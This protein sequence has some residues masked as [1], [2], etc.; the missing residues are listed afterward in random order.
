MGLLRLKIF[1]NSNTTTYANLAL[2]FRPASEVA[3]SIRINKEMI[4]EIRSRM[5]EKIEEL[6]TITLHEIFTLVLF[7]LGV[8]LCC[9]KSPENS[10]WSDVLHPDKDSYEPSS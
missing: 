5:S 2:N 6:G 4:A 7:L 8:I 3:Q 1:F 9:T 10:G